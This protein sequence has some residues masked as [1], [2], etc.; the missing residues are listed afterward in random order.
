MDV[1]FAG[2]DFIVYKEYKKKKPNSKRTIA[3]IY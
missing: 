1:C 3:V 2:L